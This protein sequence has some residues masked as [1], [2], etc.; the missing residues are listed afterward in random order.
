MNPRTA[1][2][3]LVLPPPVDSDDRADIERS[4]AGDGEAYARLVRRHQASIAS[5]LWRFTR[6]R[7]DW[8]ELVQEVFVEAYLSLRSYRARAPL[9]HWLRRIAT[10]VGYRFWK[11]RAR[12]RREAAMPLQPWD[13]VARPDETEPS[14]AA[15]EVHAVLQR[16]SPRDRLVLTLFYFEECSVAEIAALTGWSQTMVKVQSHRAR[17]RLKKLLESEP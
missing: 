8:E 2:T 13:R 15:E 12:R 1:T 10:R 11:K 16:L 4:L 14:Q 5:Y 3:G 7:G 6:D 17:N 9:A